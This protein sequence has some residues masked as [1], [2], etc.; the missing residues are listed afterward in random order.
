MANG[1]VA[2]LETHLLIALR[3]ALVR[4]ADVA[5]AFE[6][7]TEVSKMLAGLSKSLRERVPRTTST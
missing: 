3:L 6:L 4:E 1:S 2:E 7:S 5:H